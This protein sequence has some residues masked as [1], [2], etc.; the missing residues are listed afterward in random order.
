MGAVVDCVLPLEE[1][2]EAHRL[3]EAG[4]VVGKIVLDASSRA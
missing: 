3:M 1:A 4:A 2:S